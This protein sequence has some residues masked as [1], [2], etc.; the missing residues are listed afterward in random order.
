VRICEVELAH[1]LWLGVK[2]RSAWRE[3]AA[4]E[5]A[6]QVAAPHPSSLR[7]ARVGAELWILAPLAWPVP[8]ELLARRRGELVEH[9]EAARLRMARG[10]H[11]GVARPR[12]APPAP[13]V[14]ATVRSVALGRHWSVLGDEPLELDPGDAG[15][16]L[17]L[18]GWGEAVVLRA[19]ATPPLQRAPEPQCAFLLG[20][21]ALGLNARFAAA[22]LRLADA[23]RMS[24]DAESVLPPEPSEDE[25]ALALDGVRHAAREARTTLACLAHPAVARAYAAAL[26]LSLDREQPK[27][28]PT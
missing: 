14:R 2:T 6:R 19:D 13:D 21:A 28:D 27:E 3:L 1:A 9:V 24:F 20:V 15:P 11:G 26:D 17:R 22:R 4:N 10:D 7:P 25:V 5:L 12:P 16:V 18:D 23:E 8:E